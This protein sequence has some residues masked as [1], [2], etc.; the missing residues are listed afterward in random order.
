MALG[1]SLG[2]MYRDAKNVPITA[3]K[4]M[5]PRPS[6]TGIIS[7]N[8]CLTAGSRQSISRCSFP[9]RRSSQGTGNSTWMIVPTRIDP[10]YT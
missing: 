7:T 3:L 2:S 10:A 8:V 1:E 9:S 4:L 5:S 6:V